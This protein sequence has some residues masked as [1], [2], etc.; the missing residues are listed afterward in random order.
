MA[1]G[2]YETDAELLDIL[3]GIAQCVDFQLAAVA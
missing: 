1:R 2:S 3:E